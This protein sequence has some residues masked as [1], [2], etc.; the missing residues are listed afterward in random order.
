LI[1][2]VQQLNLTEPRGQA[3]FFSGLSNM[4]I[5]KIQREIENLK[6]LSAWEIRRL[7]KKSHQRYLIFDRIETQRLVESERFIL[8]LYRE[9]QKNGQRVLGE[10]SLVLNEGDPIGERLKTALE[11]AELVS[12]PLF[13]LPEKGLPYETVALLDQDL[14][15]HP[16]YYLD[17]IQEDLIGTPLDGVQRSSA[18]IFVEEREILFLNSNGLEKEESATEILVD[19]VLL[20][21]KGESLEGESQGLKRARFYRDLR[22]SEEIGKHARFAREA[23]EAGLPR[24]GRFP[25]VFGEEALDTLFNFFMLQCSGPAR[26]QNWSQFVL[27]EPVITPLRGEPLSLASNPLIN[28]GLRSRTFDDNGLPLK[29]VEVIRDNIFQKRMNT[30]RYADYLQEE[31]CGDFSNL[32]V[33]PGVK[34]LEDLL[35]RDPCYRLLRFSTFEPNPITG[36]FS[37]EIRTGY[38]VEKGRRIPVK[39][40]SVSG[41]MQEAFQEAYFSREIVQREAYVGPAAVRIEKLEIAGE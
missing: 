41:R 30:K 4:E 15:K 34:T 17:R 5:K 40:G 16:L 25:V 38:R 32:E 23:Q 10:S 37:G 6:G 31:A 27:G 13:S 12:N 24:G 2:T 39:G 7:R 3:V 1:G 35:G 26:F 11:M 28:G 36:A 29:R 22:L 33:G 8:V 9:Y 19:F 18:E 21:E 20:A 14:R